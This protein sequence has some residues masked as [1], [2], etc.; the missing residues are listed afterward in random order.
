MTKTEQAVAVGKNIAERAKEK[1]ISEVVFDR[2]GY[3]YMGRVKALAD[4]ARE[5][6]LKF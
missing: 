6:G 4:A 1:K 5:A 2:G 3:Q